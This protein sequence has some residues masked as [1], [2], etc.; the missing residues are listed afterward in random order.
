MGR[1][2]SWSHMMVV[3][4]FRVPFSRAKML[5]PCGRSAEKAFSTLG[6]V[7]KKFS[8]WELKCCC[9]VD[10][11]L[12]QT[13]KKKLQSSLKNRNKGPLIWGVSWPR[14]QILMFYSLSQFLMTF[15]FSIVL[16]NT[17]FITELPLDGW[18]KLTFRAFWYHSLFMAVVLGKIL[19]E[20]TP[21]TGKQPHTWSDDASL[22]TWDT[23]VLSSPVY[24]PSADDQCSWCFHWSEGAS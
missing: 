8:F 3:S 10:E 23:P 17:F 14:A 7:L 18:E 4:V 9:C 16:E 20:L 5:L 19:R 21:L 22:L 6:P 13:K 12:I 15:S 2:W 11:Q 24:A 1:P